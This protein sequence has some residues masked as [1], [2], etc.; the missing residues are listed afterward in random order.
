MESRRSVADIFSVAVYYDPSECSCGRQLAAFFCFCTLAKPN[1]HAAFGLF[2]FWSLLV[3]AG[4]K[5]SAPEGAVRLGS[6]IQDV[7]IPLEFQPF[8]IQLFAS[9]LIL[10]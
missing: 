5:K 3:V 8:S 1:K 10:S 7:D 9:V 6:V 2:Y 4:S